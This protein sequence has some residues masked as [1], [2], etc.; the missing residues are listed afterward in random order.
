LVTLEQRTQAADASVGLS[1]EYT[2]VDDVWADIKAVR[3]SDYL[4]G[5]Q[6]GDASTHRFTIRRRAMD[7]FSHINY[8]GRRFRK[9]NVRDPD[10]RRRVLEVMA[11]ELDAEVV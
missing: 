10:G 4:A 7:D 5:V 8:E 2:P 3:G 11:V 9:Q 6:L 1:I